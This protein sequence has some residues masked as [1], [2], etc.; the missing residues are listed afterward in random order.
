MLR[1]IEVMFLVMRMLHL[2]YVGFWFL[3][4]E[5]VGSVIL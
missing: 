4:C 2:L 1:L 5:T 3:P